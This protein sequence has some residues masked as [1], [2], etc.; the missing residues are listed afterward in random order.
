MDAWLTVLGPIRNVAFCWNKP[1]TFPCKLG[2][3]WPQ[4]SDAAAGSVALVGSAVELRQQL[5]AI[6]AEAEARQIAIAVNVM[7]PENNAFSV[8]FALGDGCIVTYD[9]NDGDPPY[10]VPLGGTKSD[11]GL[12][13]YYFG[14]NAASCQQA[15]FFRKILPLMR[16]SIALKTSSLRHSS[17]GTVVEL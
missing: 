11:K 4:A 13:S 16:W 2:C 7:T 1:V 15:T 12:V 9:G 5:A 8:V 6:R 10:F 17:N 14:G 3:Y